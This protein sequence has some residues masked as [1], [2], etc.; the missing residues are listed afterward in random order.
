MDRSHPALSAQLRDL[1]MMELVESEQ[2]QQTTAGTQSSEKQSK[3]KV[4]LIPC[5]NLDSVMTFWSTQ[6]LLRVR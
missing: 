3:R 4:L 1:K 5:G 6:F 2:L